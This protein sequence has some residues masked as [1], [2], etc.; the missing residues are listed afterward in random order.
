MYANDFFKAMNNKKII[1]DDF[2][3]QYVSSEKEKELK[4]QIKEL[5]DQLEDLKTA[6]SQ[7]LT[8]AYNDEFTPVE[9]NHIVIYTN[10][11]DEKSYFDLITGIATEI[12]EDSENVVYHDVS[13]KNSRVKILAGYCYPKA[14]YVTRVY[15]ISIATNNSRM[16]SVLVE[17]YL[18]PMFPGLEPKTKRFVSSTERFYSVGCDENASEFINTF[19]GLD[20]T[21]PYSLQVL[22]SHFVNNRSTEII[23]KSCKN[24]RTMTYMLQ[25]FHPEKPTPCHMLLNCKPEEFK[26][27]DEL[28]AV[29]E[30]NQIQRFLK[31]HEELQKTPAEL[32]DLLKKCEDWKNDLTFYQIRFDSTF[33]FQLINSYCG[34]NIRYSY[35]T[36][37][38][39]HKLY[40]FSK[41]TNYVVNET[42]NQ[43]FSSISDFI[44]SLADYMHMCDDMH[45]KPTLYSSYLV[46]T[47]DITSRNHKVFLT[48]EQERILKEHYKDFKVFKTREYAVIAPKDSNDI[49]EEGDM[50]NHCVASYIKRIL[51]NSTSI[52]FLRSTKDIEERLVT[53][54]VRDGRITQARGA[55]NRAISPE[56]KH[57]LYKFAEDRG[58][59]INL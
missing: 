35:N 8:K 20:L 42:I 50:L 11:N 48:E 1:M 7:E 26:E 28:G 53:V 10:R 38:P 22:H 30:F 54:E 13:S 29:E 12:P 33:L 44:N 46:M 23:L 2:F 39:F 37:Y 14:S 15:K 27:L 51:D 31:T 17:E 49:K 18:N 5:S 9:K 36:T 55:H 59:R 41:F 3:T 21:V 19:F 47:H 4:S 24:I 32:I 43:G 56:E 52:F 40:T 16:R 25:N 6:Y 45:I 34:C 57:A 58:L